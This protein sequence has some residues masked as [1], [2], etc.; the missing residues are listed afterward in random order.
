MEKINDVVNNISEDAL[1]QM[2][3][4]YDAGILVR[5][6][7]AKYQLSVSP[8]QFHKILP[9]Q[10]TEKECPY[11]KISMVKKRQKN[12]NPYNRAFCKKCAHIDEY[13]CD[14][15]N[16]TEHREKEQAQNQ[17]KIQEQID[18]I[19]KNFVTPEPVLIDR[20]DGIIK[21]IYLGVLL[22]RACGDVDSYFD[23]F[24]EAIPLCP[25]D[26]GTCALILRLLKDK[27]VSIHPQTP[28]DYFSEDGEKLLYVDQVYFR[29]NV[30][31]DAQQILDMLRG[32][33]ELAPGNKYVIWV[34]MAAQEV[35]QYYRY[36]CDKM[37]LLV[38]DDLPQGIFMEMART[39]PVSQCLFIVYVVI[40]KIVTM[41]IEKGY[42]TRYASSMAVDYLCNYVTKAKEEGWTMRNYN[43]PDD[44][45]ESFASRYL[46]NKVLK[47]GPEHYYEVPNK[48]R[49]EKTSS[50]DLEKDNEEQV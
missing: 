49:F 27:I 3:K 40:N 23:P 6:I 50:N 12:P 11:C 5:N 2:A 16:C 38:P 48:Y 34:C 26:D 35:A 8:R 28:V 41:K 44:L 46:Y 42:S 17:K 39:Y 7:I 14:C 30:H 24:G 29:I 10:A 45:L 4:D 31:N 25:S 19:R 43:W 37:G 15:I 22:Y 21:K 18:K 32:N 47:I 20:I 36:R 1:E 13:T 9:P 33:I